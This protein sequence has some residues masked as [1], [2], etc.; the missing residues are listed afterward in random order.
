MDGRK[1]DSVSP[2]QSRQAHVLCSGAGWVVEKEGRVCDGRGKVPC[3]GG[4]P[5]GMGVIGKEGGGLAA[6]AV[7]VEKGSSER[8]L[9]REEEITGNGKAGL[10][11]E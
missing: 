5:C 2:S 11:V 6:I 3:R 8:K 4:H 1:R 7:S 10:K 9:P